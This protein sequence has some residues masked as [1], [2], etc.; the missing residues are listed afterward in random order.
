MKEYKG[1]FF[2]ALVLLLSLTTRLQAQDSLYTP[3]PAWDNQ[4]FYGNKLTWSTESWKFSGEFQFRLDNDMRG[5]D[6]YF[7]EGVASYMANKNWEVV[8]DLRFSV[9]SDKYEYRPGLGIIYKNNWG[10]VRLNQLVHQLKWQSDI[11]STGIVKNGL[12]YVL[13]FNKELNDK[14]IFSAAAGGLYRWS[15]RMTG[16]QFLRLMLGGTYRFNEKTSLNLS[17]FVGFE[18]DGRHWANIGGPLVQFVINLD[19]KSKYIPAH[20][21]NF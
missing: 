4:L 19:N 16:V 9:Y 14:Y 10:E 18:N 21:F 5:L 8:P 12:R 20:Y 1:L 17:Y 11:E 7:I 15:E 3:Q 6:L 2:I 13:F